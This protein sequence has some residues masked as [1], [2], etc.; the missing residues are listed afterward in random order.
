MYT[1]HHRTFVFAGLMACATLVASAPAQSTPAPP[2]PVPPP[3]IN[4]T[5]GAAPA[6]D[7]TAAQ[8]IPGITDRPGA[9]TSPTASLFGE[10]F[11]STTAGLSFLPPANCTMIKKPVADEIVEYTSDEKSWILRVT[12]SALP[13]PTPLETHVDIKTNQQVKGLIDVTVEHMIEGIN[14]QVLRKDVINVGDNYVGLI[15][16]RF[17]LG[18]DKWLR[19]QAILQVND[20]LYYIFNLTTPAGSANQGADE[21]PDPREKL[22]VDTFNGMLDSIKLIDRSSIKLDQN[23]RLFRTRAVFMNWK[24]ELFEK[25]M[26]DKQYFLLESED[27]PIGYSYVEE[28]PDIL[29]GDPGVNIYVRAR[30]F[31]KDGQVETGSK[32]FT[33]F[34]LKHEQWAHVA[35][36]KDAKGEVTNHGSEWGDS[37]FKQHRVFDDRFGGNDSKD[38]KQ[39]RSL[40]VDAHSLDVT[41]IG[42]KGNG[43]PLHRDLPPFYIPQ[44]IGQMLPRLLPLDDAKTYLFASYVNEAREV[45]LRYV[46]VEPDRDVTFNGQHIRATVISDRIG[47]EGS[48]TL[49]YFDANGEF[50]GSENKTAKFMVLPIDAASIL[51]RWPDAV[52]TRPED[53]RR[54]TAEVGPTSDAPPARGLPEPIH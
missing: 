21:P 33:T 43:E 31:T 38:P 32:M 44:A 27:Q 18:A 7:Q 26:K 39:P 20:Q 16:V 42:K 4:P 35:V 24:P 37:D 53:L 46:D 36:Y 2:A 40:M 3:L 12:R 49:H 1:R 11:E 17:T 34:D 10:R 41:Y 25:V 15:V 45:M 6:G 52:L 48:A 54:P 19:Q 51:A 5:A 23:A 14:P 50:L 47:L 13:V 9:T 28:H 30:T 8:A 29:D 22:A